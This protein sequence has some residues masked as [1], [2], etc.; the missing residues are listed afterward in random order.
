MVNICEQGLNVCQVSVKQQA[1]H[2]KSVQVHH[3]KQGNMNTK[4]VA[5][6]HQGDTHF[7]GC[8]APGPI[9]SGAASPQANYLPPGATGKQPDSNVKDRHDG[10]IQV[11]LAL[12]HVTV[13][14]VR[15][16]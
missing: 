13:A 15:G 2:L 1:V 10:A 6:V 12:G 16:S 7:Q 14:V 5:L 4:I 11:P 8:T 3:G 9:S